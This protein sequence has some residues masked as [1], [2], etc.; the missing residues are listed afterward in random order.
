MTSLTEFSLFPELP[1]EL[2]LAIWDRVAQPARIVGNVPCAD[3]WTRI[4]QPPSGQRS[5]NCS[6]EKHP[7]WRLRYVVQPRDQVI[8]PPLHACKESRGVWLPRYYRPPRY[9]DLPGY[10][11]SHPVFKGYRLRFDVPFISYETDIFT[12]I[13]S[14]TWADIIGG[15][16]IIHRANFDPFIGLDRKRI[17]QAAFC[18]I[19]EGFLAAII[20]LKLQTLPRL[21]SMSLLAMGPDPNTWVYEVSKFKEMPAVDI[22]ELD[23]VLRDIPHENIDRHPFFDACRPQRRYTQLTPMVRPLRTFFAVFRAW[24]WHANHWDS[25]QLVGEDPWWMFLDYVL[26]EDNHQCPLGLVGCG[27]GGH[28]KEEMMQWEPDFVIDCKMVCEKAW[29]VKLD[30]ISLFDVN[31]LSTYD[32]EDEGCYEM[33]EALLG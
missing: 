17:Q 19:G 25:N 10:D 1:G 11:P 21:R 31:G 24:L 29:A 2:R 6:K 26:E 32:R 30:L 14:W 20:G 8:F 27:S 28:S 9:L 23:C 12:V 13:D 16:E 22:Q 4:R 3:C 7:D 15:W 33:M 5:A 18:E